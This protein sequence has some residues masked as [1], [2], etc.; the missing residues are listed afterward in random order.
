MSK[1]FIIKDETDIKRIM[2]LDLFGVY[3]EEL[4]PEVF[5]DDINCFPREA[6]NTSHGKTLE[7]GIILKGKKEDGSFCTIEYAFYNLDAE[8]YQKYYLD[9]NEE[10]KSVLDNY[11][12][13][14]VKKDKDYLSKWVKVAFFLGHVAFEANINDE[15]DEEV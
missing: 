15:T 4:D 10:V 9:E 5:L 12:R 2:M 6:Y 8:Y 3:W 1:R 13:E 14:H 7:P 11:I